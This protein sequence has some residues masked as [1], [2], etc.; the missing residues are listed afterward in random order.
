[1][2]FTMLQKHLPLEFK[3]QVAYK[4]LEFVIIFLVE[5]EQ[6]GQDKPRQKS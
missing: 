2:L 5:L 6:E 3:F 1:M 4:C